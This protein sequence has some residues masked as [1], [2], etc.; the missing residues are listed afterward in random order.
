MKT[1]A[2]TSQ[3]ILVAQGTDVKRFHISADD[4]DNVFYGGR[5]TAAPATACAAFFNSV[6]A[7][8]LWKSC[9]GGSILL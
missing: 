5:R 7:Q 4:R 9:V 6:F 1:H 3:I 2:L 8:K